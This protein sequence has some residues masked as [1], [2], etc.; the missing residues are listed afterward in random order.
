MLPPERSSLRR[1]AGR[2]HGLVPLQAHAHA[3]ARTRRGHLHAHLTLRTRQL[4]VEHRRPPAPGL[5]PC[6][7]PAGVRPGGPPG[8][9]SRP[10]SPWADG[11]A[12]SASQSHSELTAPP[13]RPAI[14]PWLLR[15]A[16]GP[17]A[18]AAAPAPALGA[19]M[20]GMA[21]G[22][23]GPPSPPLPPSSVALGGGA[24]G[25]GP[26]SG[27]GPGKPGGGG[28][29]PPPAT[30]AACRCCSACIP[31]GQNARSSA[32]ASFHAVPVQHN[33]QR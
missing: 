11:E 3:H 25:G 8:D 23:A 20:L 2:L 1:Q 17:P 30:I 5:P 4:Q 10:P 16:S 29:S 32:P 19:K 33:A 31:E 7:P 27:G 15:R 6:R 28:G 12:R 26:G 13:V 21:M 22:S 14:A 18:D 24:P 9:T